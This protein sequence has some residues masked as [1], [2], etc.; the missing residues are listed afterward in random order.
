MISVEAS[1]K[2]K[3]KPKQTHISAKQSS[4]MIKWVWLKLRFEKTNLCVDKYSD[5]DEQEV[6]DRKTCCNVCCCQR[7]EK[8]A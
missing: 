1:L 2:L 7:G 3:P 4:E 6:S 8:K 5:Q